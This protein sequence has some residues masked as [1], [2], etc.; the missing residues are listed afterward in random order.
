MTSPRDPEIAHRYTVLKQ[1]A[2]VIAGELHMSMDQVY[3]SLRRQ[4]IPR[5]LPG[6]TPRITD[7]IRAEIVRRYRDEKMGATTLAR[8]FGIDKK[9]VYNIL[10]KAGTGTRPQNDR[11]GDT[12]TTPASIAAKLAPTGRKRGSGA[13]GQKALNEGA[14]DVLTN[15]AAYWLGYLICDGAVTRPAGRTSLRLFLLQGLCHLGHLQAL[16]QFLQADNAI[17]Y[18]KHKDP[19]G[20]EQDHCC[21]A[22]TSLRLCEKLATYGMQGL[23]PTRHA[24]D[25]RL[26]DHPHFWRGCV[27]ADGSIAEAGKGLYLS[28]HEP[29]LAQWRVFVRK[30]GLDD[31]RTEQ[32]PGCLVDHLRVDAA[33]RVARAI[34]V[35]APGTALPDK[36]ARA[37]TLAR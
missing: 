10:V 16:K 12:Y 7:D 23:K 3:E 11:T 14:F 8:E 32:K 26:L 30:I 18:G 33:R 17:T 35:D 9:S 24:Q 27:D 2:R 37:R 4:N 29:L 1:P 25:A 36:L 5:D 22:V 13:T 20:V 31:V 19:A 28:G 34:Y 15:E 21:L 6:G